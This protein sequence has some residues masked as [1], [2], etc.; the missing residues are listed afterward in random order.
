M[1]WTK[2]Q[3]KIITQLEQCTSE[4]KEK[5]VMYPLTIDLQAIFTILLKAQMAE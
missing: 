1:T 4:N 2:W 3:D 5:K